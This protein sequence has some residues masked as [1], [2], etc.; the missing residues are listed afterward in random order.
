MTQEQQKQSRRECQY[1]VMFGKMGFR[2]PEWTPVDAHYTTLAEAESVA[3]KYAHWQILEV[4]AEIIKS[5]HAAPEKTA[6]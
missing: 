1:V 3:S 6:G 4:S 2:G 5:S